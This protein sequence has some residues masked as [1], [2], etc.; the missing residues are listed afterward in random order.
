MAYSNNNVLYNKKLNPPLSQCYAE[1]R[2]V[3]KWFK[4]K[5]RSRERLDMT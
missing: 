2:L 4:K 1:A 3:D 5:D